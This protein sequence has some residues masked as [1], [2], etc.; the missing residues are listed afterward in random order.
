MHCQGSARDKV[1]HWYKILNGDASGEIQPMISAHD[2]D[3]K[4][5][6]GKMLRFCTS[7]IFSTFAEVAGYA[8]PYSE[9]EI[10]TL[11]KDK[12]ESFMEDKFLDDVFDAESR[13]EH[14]VFCNLVC[15]KAS[16]VFSAPTLRK[17]YLDHAEVPMKY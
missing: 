7:D 12:V 16:Y 5:N 3:F 11:S 4:P 14:D 6:F 9:E 17:L 8:Q 1:S 2:K 15:E 13:L 10:E